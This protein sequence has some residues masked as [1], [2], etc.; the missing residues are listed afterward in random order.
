LREMQPELWYFLHSINLPIQS[1]LPEWLQTLLAKQ[2]DLEDVLRLWD[3]YIAELFSDRLNLHL[4]VCMA[5]LDFH[6]DEISSCLTSEDALITFFDRLPRVNVD[7]VVRHARNIREEV[8]T[9]EL[10]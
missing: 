3:T 5:L 6:K 1:W 10:I 2:L 8:R 9:R 4:Y 7:E